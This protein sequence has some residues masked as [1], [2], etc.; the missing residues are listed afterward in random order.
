MDRCFVEVSAICR[1]V[2]KGLVEEALTHSWCFSET[3]KNHSTGY[4]LLYYSYILSD[5]SLFISRVTELQ[6]MHANNRLVFN[7]RHSAFTWL[8]TYQGLWVYTHK[9]KISLVFPFFYGLSCIKSSIHQVLQNY[10]MG[11]HRIVKQHNSLA[12]SQKT[13]DRTEIYK[14]DSNFLEQDRTPVEEV[15]AR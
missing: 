12:L 1:C 6:Q 7:N 3:S 5:S 14:V 4:C 15:S 9:K 10:S 2:W 8:T 11:I 13:D